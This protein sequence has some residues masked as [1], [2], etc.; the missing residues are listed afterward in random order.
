[1]P[2]AREK[3]A[4]APSPMPGGHLLGWP[5]TKIK[6]RGLAEEDMLRSHNRRGSKYEEMRHRSGWKTLE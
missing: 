4:S 5:H 1:M 3:R 2:G 6:V